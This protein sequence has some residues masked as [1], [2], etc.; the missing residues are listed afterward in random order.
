M[1]NWD[2]QCQEVRC[3]MGVENPLLTAN[4]SEI[5]DGGQRGDVAVDLLTGRS[6]S[7]E[8]IST[9]EAAEVFARDHGLMDSLVLF[10]GLVLQRRD[11]VNAVRIDLISD[12]EVRDWFTICFCIQTSAPIERVLTFDEHL[13]GFMYDQMPLEH[14]VYFAV[15]FEF[16]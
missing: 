8:A 11:V 4:R 12:P 9:S 10:R 2:C 1:V 16:T 6:L 5:L 13:R 14:H 7:T 3:E 15:R